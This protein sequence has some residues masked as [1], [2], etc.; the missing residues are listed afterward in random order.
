MKQILLYTILTFT[1]FSV[2]AY[3]RAAKVEPLNA[4]AHSEPV[5]TELT[6][7]NDE[8]GT[9]AIAIRGNAVQVHVLNGQGQSLKVYDLVGRLKYESH[10]DSNDKTFHFSLSKGI[11]LINL[12]K[13]TRRISVAG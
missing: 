2:S 7:V 13:T 10:V 1:L 3:G 11:Y 8:V 4:I 5:G 12:G 9:I 6:E